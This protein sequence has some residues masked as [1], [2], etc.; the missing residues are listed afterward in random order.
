MEKEQILPDKTETDLKVDLKR[1][2]DILI[3]K[4]DDINNKP[5]E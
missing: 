2:A 4:R 5:K 3:I 1:T